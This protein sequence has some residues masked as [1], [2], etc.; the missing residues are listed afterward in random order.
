M[1]KDIDYYLELPYTIEI[2]PES[3]GG[4][5]VAIKELPGCMT[6]ADSPE[7]G[8]EEIR[9]LQAEWLQIALEDGLP[10]PEPKSDGQY[11]GNFRLRVSRSLHH[12]LVE[13][14]EQDNVSLNTYCV[15]AL[16]EAV[17]HRVGNQTRPPVKDTQTNYQTC[18]EDLSR[19]AGLETELGQGNE[20]AVAKWIN[21][22]R[23]E[24]V[25]AFETERLREG[26]RRLFFLANLL[27][28]HGKSNP[29]ISSIADL[30]IR[31]CDLVDLSTPRQPTPVGT[32][33]GEIDEIIL[34][35]NQPIVQKNYP[36]FFT[37][38]PE[39]PEEEAEVSREYRQF[40]EMAQKGMPKSR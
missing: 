6:E 18:L 26:S 23:E 21:S 13:S 5:F 11:S 22:I 3:S 32:R 4:W 20:L 28:I 15:T 1:N 35:V 9:E 16:A 36:V 10:I 17:G 38:L 29:F 25:A 2:I 39:T 31:L 40:L 37:K 33:Y 27:C 8:L 34:K 7:E 12:K 24:T 30:V 14:A 19:A